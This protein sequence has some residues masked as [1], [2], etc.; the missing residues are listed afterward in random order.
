M[1]ACDGVAPSIDRA[2]LLRAA[3]TGFVTGALKKGSMF[4]V[5]DAP[6]AKVGVIGSGQGMTEVRRLVQ[7]AFFRRRAVLVCLRQQS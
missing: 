2:G 6:G 3:Q 5:P 7:A 4:S 1:W